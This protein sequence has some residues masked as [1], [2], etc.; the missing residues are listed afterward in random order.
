MK[1]I[2]L[3][4]RMLLAAIM[5]IGSTSMW[6]QY[7]G[8]GNF[9]K[10]SSAD[11][12]ADGYYVI[13]YGETYAM[14]NDYNSTYLARTAITVDASGT[15]ANPSGSIV[16][17]IKA[18]DLGGK[19]IFN[20]ESGKY[21]SY[22][23]SSNNVQTVDAVSTLNQCWDITY[24]SNLFKITNKQL[25]TRLL[26]YNAASGSERFCCYTG[27][28][29]NLTLYKM[30]AFGDNVAATP[31]FSSVTGVY[32]API[33]ISLSSVT[34]GASIYY[35]IDGSDPTTSST[36]YTGAFTVSTTTT[37]KAIAIKEGMDNSSVATVTYTF[38][39]EVADIAAF[40][41]L[42]P[43]TVGKIT[44]AIT[45]AY[46]NGSN[47]F[48]QDASSWVLIYGSTTQ[49]Y[50][51]GDRLTGV[52]GTLVMYGTPAY[53]ELEL[54]TGVALPDGV[55]GT[56]AT[57]ATL[58][59]DDLTN[60]DLNRYVTFENVE[61]AA[62]VTYTGTGTVD[63]TIV[64]ND[65][66]M[67]IRDYFRLI[68]GTFEGGSRVN[69]TGFV[70]YA[71]SAILIYLLSIEPSGETSIAA[72]PTF[73]P[74]AGSFVDPVSVTISTVTDGA[75]I[76]YTTDGSDPTT[77][78][79][80]YTGPFTVSTT[81]TI[82]AIAMKS[83]MEN[84]SV[85]SATYSFP[86]EVANIAEFISLDPG[87]VAK[88]TGTVTAVYQNGNNLF[89]QDAS[90]WVLIYGNPGGKTYQNGDRLT[91]VI[92]KLTMY[93]SATSAEYPEVDITGITLPDGV[94]GSP[95]DP[96]H[97][98]PADLTNADLNRYIAFVNVEI[99][100]D[101]TYALTQTSGTIVNGDGTMVI[102]DWY[103]LISAT[104]VKGDKVDVTGLVRSF[105]GIQI[106]LL[107]IE[108]TV[109]LG[110]SNPNSDRANVF[111]ENGVI[112]V[113][114]LSGTAKI[115]VFDIAGRLITQTNATEIPVNAKGVY[116]VK[117]NDQ[118]YKVVNK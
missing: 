87:T 37:V 46:Q 69:L 63:G 88:I 45:V 50:Q 19:T 17:E 27:T 96:K 99:A 118:A 95:V 117:V 8:A 23:G 4:R 29:Q 7:A 61:L 40:N 86:V 59:P 68:S 39:V 51:S 56:P 82:K 33:S 78:S 101:V 36:L 30:E 44:G 109:N 90:S 83:G 14:S 21:V 38:P 114:N 5:L 76:Y 52:I 108:K 18:N 22:T 73:T 93:S 35:T 12:L 49:T 54:I 64:T 26:Q 31:T 3:L 65:G 16:W 9:T 94:A 102:A 91:N 103:K 25:T 67:I 110:I 85:A 15:I 113:K 71:S 2:T 72:T 60:S 70:R 43:G 92:G 42:A 79:T 81:T 58:T 74:A 107:S 57:P 13:A 66:T 80:L 28:Q 98:D 97:V 11:D 48:V 75:S 115:S 116:V 112:Y 32:T 6:G 41:A 104:F 24:E 111:A 34:D 106:Y 10:I 55:A 47:L 62:N 89:V 84:S 53:P 20:E 1:K 100:D 105:N 77:S